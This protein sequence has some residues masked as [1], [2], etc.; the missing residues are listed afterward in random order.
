MRQLQTAFGMFGRAQP[1]AEPFTLLAMRCQWL[2]RVAGSEAACEQGRRSDDNGND[3]GY[4]HDDSA[5]R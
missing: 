1:E 4:P 3:E 2:P 5:S